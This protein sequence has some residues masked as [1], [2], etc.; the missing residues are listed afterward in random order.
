M[1]TPD[2]VDVTVSYFQSIPALLGNVYS[3][4]G[5][6]KAQYQQINIILQLM[7]P[8]VHKASTQF[9]HKVLDILPALRL[10]RAVSTTESLKPLISLISCSLIQKY[11]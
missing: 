9:C 11:Q 2:G 5:S 3:T 4:L 10:K 7:L 8:P 1:F 6:R